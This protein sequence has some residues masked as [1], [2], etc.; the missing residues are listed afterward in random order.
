MN[1]LKPRL[2]AICKNPDNLFCADCGARGP[3]WSSVKLG[4]LICPQ[5]AGIHRKIGTHISFVQSVTI[6][7]WKLEWVETVEKIGNRIANMYFEGNVPDH[8]KK[9]SP[10]DTSNTG[11]D[12]MDTAQAAKLEKWIR[13]KYELKVF[14]RE[15][16]PDP[17]GLVDDGKDPRTTEPYG[18]PPPSPKK[19]P[20]KNKQL[21]QSS[22]V[23][24]SPIIAPTVIPAQQG[25]I[26]P[27]NFNW[28]E[29]VF[30]V[31]W[32]RAHGIDV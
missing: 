21:V 24:E 32:A 31:S 19:S 6:D 17:R 20:K 18:K 28:K 16:M 13:N 25:I 3:R 9:P 1:V 29:N 7:K 12:I 30:I 14:V 11:G 15:D 4:I 26:L 2:D 8:I 27:T 22:P 10:S 5:C 23:L